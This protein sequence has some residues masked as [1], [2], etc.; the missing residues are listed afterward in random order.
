METQNKIKNK[1][2]GGSVEKKA[3]EYYKVYLSLKKHYPTLN[4]ESL[5]KHDLIIENLINKYALERLTELI[6]EDK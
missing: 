4:H 6:K 3:Q 1:T 5:A 2:I